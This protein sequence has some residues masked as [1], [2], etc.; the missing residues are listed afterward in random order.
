[1]ALQIT[2]GNT[3]DSTVLDEI[4][5][6]LRGKLYHCCVLQLSFP[7]RLPI[8][9]SGLTIFRMVEIGGSRRCTGVA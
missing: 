2:P 4:T 7:I 8:C 1:M 9:A 6:H 5:Q 3:A